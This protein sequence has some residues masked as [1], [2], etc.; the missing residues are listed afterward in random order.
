MS[1]ENGPVKGSGGDGFLMT[2]MFGHDNPLDALAEN[3][4]LTG[5]EIDI[6][7]VNDTG[8][9]MVA[10]PVADFVRKASLDRFDA[11]T[12]ADSPL[13]KRAKAVA[14]RVERI[15]TWELQYDASNKLIR[16]REI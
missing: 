4:G 10:D 11:P 13:A 6:Y 1:N 3:G 14:A 2:Y 16:A 12:P 5:D 15:G 8:E 7:K 9:S